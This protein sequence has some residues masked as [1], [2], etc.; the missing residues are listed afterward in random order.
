MNVTSELFSHYITLANNKVK[1]C[2]GSD[3]TTEAQEAIQALESFS[4]YMCKIVENVYNY[5]EQAVVLS[6]EH[7][8]A[9][10]EK[11]RD[12]FLKK[13]PENEKAIE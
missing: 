13:D 12:D 5:F 4:V 6:Q 3:Q 10:H 11:V 9:Q 7:L 8:E 1:K 2:K